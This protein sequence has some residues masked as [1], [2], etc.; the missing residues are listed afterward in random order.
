MTNPVFPEYGFFCRDL[1]QILPFVFGKVY[2]EIDKGKK[3]LQ[4]VNK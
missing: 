1:S 3:Y 2:L 4:I